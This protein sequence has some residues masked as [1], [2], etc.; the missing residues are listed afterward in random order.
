M[1]K[2]TAQAFG[3][4]LEVLDMEYS[5]SRIERVK[6]II[7]DYIEFWKGPYENDDGLILAKK[8]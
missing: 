5:R 7:E 6:G 8:E 1:I 4:V 3:G 2:K